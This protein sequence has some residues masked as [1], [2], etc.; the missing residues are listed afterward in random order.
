MF[1]QLAVS[2]HRLRVTAML[3]A[4]VAE[5]VE[6]AAAVKAEITIAALDA[7]EEI[8]DVLEESGQL[9]GSKQ[10]IVAQACTTTTI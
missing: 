2:F 1:F 9:V 8:L 10:V 5:V 4:K 7:L 6:R 3:K